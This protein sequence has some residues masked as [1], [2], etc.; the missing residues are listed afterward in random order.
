MKNF[1]LNL[2]ECRMNDGGSVGI[3]ID[4]RAILETSGKCI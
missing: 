2:E 1:E 4:Q 3:E